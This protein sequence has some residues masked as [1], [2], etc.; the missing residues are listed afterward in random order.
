[1]TDSAWELA[2]S[3]WELADSGWELADSGWEL[4]DSVWEDSDIRWD[5]SRG[6]WQDELLPG[7]SNYP[8]PS[9]GRADGEIDPQGQRHHGCGEGA[10]S[11]TRGRVCSPDREF[12]PQ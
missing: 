12:D 10:T 4:T 7:V 6:G 2:D 1:L 5:F 3:G 9:Q 11:D 8:R